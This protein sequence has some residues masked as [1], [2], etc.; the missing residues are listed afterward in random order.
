MPWFA[1]QVAPQH[2]RKVANILEYK[3][4]Q[5]Y[6]P[7]HT[8]TRKWSDRVK[9][10]EQPLFPN[11]VF[12][13]IDP[14][15]MKPVLA[16]AGVVRIVGFGGKPYPV[17]EEEIAAIQQI[18]KSGWKTVAVVRPQIGERVQVI[19]GPLKGI[20]G[21]LSRIDKK[22]HFVVSIEAIMKSIAVV[23]DAQMVT[24]TDGVIRQ[25]A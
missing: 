20:T 7:T 13:R 16:T 24:L 25:P 23:V 15:A 18:V 10:L 14:L 12:C 17:Q 2:E 21:I 4:H 1:V 3:G 22:N 19:E 6:L 11:Y 5:Q 8:V 9:T